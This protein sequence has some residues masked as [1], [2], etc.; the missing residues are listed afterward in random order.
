[1]AKGHQTR[2]P[3]TEK[4]GQFVESKIS[5]LRKSKSNFGFGLWEKGSEQKTSL[6][7]LQ[8]RAML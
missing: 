7:D 2:I 8:M 5:N 1:M 4:Q 6:K 3:G